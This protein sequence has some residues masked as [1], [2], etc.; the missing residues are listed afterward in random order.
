MWKQRAVTLCGC[1]AALPLLMGCANGSGGPPQ[2]Y[3]PPAPVATAAPD[4]GAQVCAAGPG[5]PAAILVMLP[6]PGD[7]LTADPQ[8]WAAQG[9]DVVTPS[10]SQIYRIAADQQAAAA[11]LIAEAQAMAEAPIWLVGPSPAVEAA[12]ASMPPAGPGR[13]AG[14][15]MTAA[16]SGLHTCSETMTYAYSGNGAAPQVKVSKSGNACPPGAPFGIETNQ[17]VMPM[18][19]APMAPS[20]PPRPPR[21]IEAATPA[22]ASPAARHAAVARVAELIKAAPSS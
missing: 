7:M 3:A 16:A 22:G 21:L 5:A 14:V 10:P 12:M 9:F 20:V 2:A 8:L 4:T 17:G 1:L 19:P 13:V 15:V 18:S 6:G 11:R